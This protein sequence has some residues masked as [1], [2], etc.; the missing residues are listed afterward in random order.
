MNGR[1]AKVHRVSFFLF[2]FEKKK[3]KHGIRHFEANPF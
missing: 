3:E 1:V 2:F